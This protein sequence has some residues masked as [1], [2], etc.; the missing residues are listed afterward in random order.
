MADDIN[1]DYRHSNGAVY[2][3]RLHFIWI[4]RRRRKVLVG[5]VAQRLDTLLREK[6]ADLDL[7][8][9]R[10]AIQPD[11]LHLFV[12]VDPKIAPAQIAYRLKG[13]TARLLRQE[14]PHL[15]KMPSMW[16]TSYFVS[17]A[18]TV[19]AA[20]IEQYIQSQSTRA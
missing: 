5:P 2:L 3:L 7:D 20:T 15:R 12:G 8:V 10:L 6:A 19:A 4:P 16:T 17:S 11:H 1:Q 9:V 18:G 13:Y 14:F